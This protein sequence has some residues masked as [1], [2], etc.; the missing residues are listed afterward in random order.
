MRLYNSRSKKKEEFI[1]L[2]EGAVSMYHCGPTVYDYAHI[3][4]FRAYILADL[5]RRLF[6]H[7]GFLVK[8]VMNITD[9]GHLAS[10]ADEGEDKMTMALKREG[11]ELTLENMKSLAD[12]YAA[13]FVEDLKRLNIKK[14]HEMPRAS[15]HI[16]AQIALIKRLEERGLIYRT[17]DGLYFDTGAYPEY[18]AFGT[19]HQDDEE[20]S[21]IGANKEKKNHRDFALWKFSAALGWESLWGKGFPGW[22]VECSAMSMEA[23]GDSFDIHTGGIDLIGTHHTN[24]IAQSEAA[25]GKPLARFWLHNAFLSVD[26]EKMSK[27]K[28]NIF[29]LRDIAEKGANPLA[30]RYWLLTAQYRN[31]VNFTWDALRAAE[32]ALFKIY[33]QFFL[34][35]ETEGKPLPSYLARFFTFVEDDLDTPRA[36]ALVWK[37][38]KDDTISDGDKKATLLEMDAVLGLSVVSLLSKKV[39]DAVLSLVEEREDARKR[40]D[41]A[42]ADALREQVKSHGFGLNDTNEGAVAFP[43]PQTL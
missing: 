25:T 40:K 10:D 21:R 18:G 37:M 1:P 17:S 30:Y 31:P 5:L 26:G 36:V 4:N 43:L 6:E 23:L 7:A 16:P 14:P 34:F 9:V 35:G 8:Q 32:H 22:H 27:S 24:E 12:F 39:P 13:R 41:W 3:G 2:H 19:V 33:S 29:T 11:R 38:L 20:H 15:E 28:Q 42:K